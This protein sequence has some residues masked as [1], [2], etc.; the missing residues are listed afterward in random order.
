MDGQTRSRECLSKS[1]YNNTCNR[2]DDGLHVQFPGYL[3]TGITRP[4]SNGDHFHFVDP[5][6]P[7]TIW[8]LVPEKSSVDFLASRENWVRERE[9]RNAFDDVVSGSTTVGLIINRVSDRSPDVMSL[10]IQDTHESKDDEEHEIRG[11][12]MCRVSLYS[13]PVKGRTENQ[14][15]NREGMRVNALKLSNVQRWCVF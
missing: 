2:E 1:C 4:K 15:E 7:E 10:R 12:F 9:R 13:V 6:D 14:L 3:I 5:D 8:R 11:R